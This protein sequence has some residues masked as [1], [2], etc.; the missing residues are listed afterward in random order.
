[1]MM[2]DFERFRFR[3]DDRFRNPK[4]DRVITQAFVRRRPF[5]HFVK[6]RLAMLGFLQNADVAYNK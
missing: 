5:L 4:F 6:L 3:S 1:M 2:I